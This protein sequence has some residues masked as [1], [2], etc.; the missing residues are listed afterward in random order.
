MAGGRD[1]V[2]DDV[3]A[4]Q[5]GLPVIQ[6]D[7]GRAGVPADL[8]EQTAS[9]VVRPTIPTPPLHGIVVVTWAGRT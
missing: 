6:R 4:G 3:T 8:D 7:R 1:D 5:H 9:G 2:N